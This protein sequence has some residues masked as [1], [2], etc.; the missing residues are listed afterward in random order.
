MNAVGHTYG[1]RPYDNLATNNQW[2]AWV[3]GGEGLHNNHHGAPRSPKFSV[4]KSEFDPA[5]PVLRVMEFFRLAK[6]GKVKS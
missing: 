5:W 4:R 1:K 3:S 2:L 6:L